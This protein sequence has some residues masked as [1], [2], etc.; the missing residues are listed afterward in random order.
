MVWILGLTGGIGSGKTAASDYLQQQGIEVVDSDVIA[1]EVVQAGQPALKQIQQQFGDEVLLANGELDRAWLR[2][3]VFANPEERRLLE[4]ITH[5]AIRQLT[6]ERLNSARSPYVILAS[7]L[8]FESGQYQLVNRSLV[9]DVP[10]EVQL[11]RASQRDGNSEEQIRRIM[12]SQLN[13]TDRLGKADDVVNNSRSLADLYQQL[14]QLHQT[15]LQLAS[16]QD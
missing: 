6:I 5:P 8:L 14:R 16:A 15:Y 10:E 12:Q 1:R 3:R 4:A 2:Q 9:V 7:P 13:R 11:L